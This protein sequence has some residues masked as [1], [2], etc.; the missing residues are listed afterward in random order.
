MRRFKVVHALACLV[1]MLFVALGVLSS[2]LISVV[3]DRGTIQST[4]V[5]SLSSDTE[6][7]FFDVDFTLTSNC[8]TGARLYAIEMPVS[9]FQRQQVGLYESPLH[10][11]T[12]PLC[13]EGK[14]DKWLV[15]NGNAY[16]A[17]FSERD[18][19]KLHR[20]LAFEKQTPWQDYLR[21]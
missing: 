14:A 8:L 21:D 18:V 15:R 1:A 2:V 9:Q 20:D 13:I 12:A 3:S 16:Y 4:A 11:A 10:Q 7:Q 6:Y 19:R 5:A 17:A